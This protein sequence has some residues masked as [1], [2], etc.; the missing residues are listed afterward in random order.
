MKR[1]LIFLLTVVLIL[2][3]ASC[4]SKESALLGT[5]VSEDGEEFT[6]GKSGSVVDADEELCL[7]MDLNGQVS[8]WEMTDGSTIAFR[9]TYRDAATS[10]FELSGDTLVLCPNDYLRN[11]TRIRYYTY[12]RKK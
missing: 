2:P 5:W 7:I 1:L 3:T 4:G 10:A 11:G 8:S 9:D 12:T 6:L